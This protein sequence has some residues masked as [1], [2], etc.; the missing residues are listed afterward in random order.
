MFDGTGAAGHD[1]PEC[2][3]GRPHTQMEM[4]WSVPSLTLPRQSPGKG[5]TA[6][7]DVSL[8]LR[9][10]VVFDPGTVSFKVMSCH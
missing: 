2:S 8:S 1:F 10:G 4:W 3:Q 7:P 9:G 6:L 5:A